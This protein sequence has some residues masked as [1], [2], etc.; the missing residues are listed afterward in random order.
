MRLNRN[1]IEL[2]NQV[3]LKISKYWVTQASKEELRIQIHANYFTSHQTLVLSVS[4]PISATPL[5]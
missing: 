1:G 4:S 3:Q 2:C 5:L